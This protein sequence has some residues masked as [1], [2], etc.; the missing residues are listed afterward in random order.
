MPPTE[1]YLVTLLRQLPQ[2]SEA[3]QEQLLGAA[4][5]AHPADARPLLLLAAHYAQH[6]SFDRAEA[7]YIE[8]LHRAPELAIARFQLGLLQFSCARPVTALATFAPLALLPDTHP[9]HLFKKA[10]ECLANDRLQEASSWLQQGIASNHDNAPLN[11][12]MGKLVRQIEAQLSAAASAAM[13][14][15][16]T[17]AETSPAEQHFLVTAYRNLH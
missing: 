1:N 2:A 10:F 12:D 8:A 15:N 17:Q 6:Q 13:P 16:A 7:C 5:T 9:L 11:D 3:E 14:V 4:I